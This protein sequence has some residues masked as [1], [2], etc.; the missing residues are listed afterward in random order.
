MRGFIK[1]R[2]GWVGRVQKVFTLIEMLV[3]VG[4]I[5]A[6]VAIIMPQHIGVGLILWLKAWEP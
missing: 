5:V 4:I 1:N 6:L 3:V 2:L